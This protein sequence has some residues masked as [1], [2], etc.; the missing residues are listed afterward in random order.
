MT[1][2]E[3]DWICIVCLKPVGTEEYP[4]AVQIEVEVEPNG[5]FYFV[6]HGDCEMTDEARLRLAREGREACSSGSD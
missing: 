3:D 4:S 2:C 1:T 5:R 6:R